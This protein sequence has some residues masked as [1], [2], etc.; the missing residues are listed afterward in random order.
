M[1][2]IEQTEVERRSLILKLIAFGHSADK[3]FEIVLDYSR[4]DKWAKLWVEAICGKQ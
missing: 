1:T 3:A 2:A 4:G